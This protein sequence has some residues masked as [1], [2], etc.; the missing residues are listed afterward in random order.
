[1]QT[2]RMFPP[3]RPRTKPRVMADVIDAGYRMVRIHCKRC[4]LNEWRANAGDQN[5]RKVPC[6]IC[7]EVA[8]GN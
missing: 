6:P 2:L 3:V 5:R 1:M 4:E 7:N 8:S